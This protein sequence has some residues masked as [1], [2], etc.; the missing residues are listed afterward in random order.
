MQASARGGTSIPPFQGLT[1]P[2]QPMEGPQRIARWPHPCNERAL[3]SP[4]IAQWGRQPRQRW[5][6]PA[7]PES[8]TRCLTPT[9]PTALPRPAGGE[10]RLQNVGLPCQRAGSLLLAEDGSGH[11]RRGKRLKGEVGR[12][13]PG[14]SEQGGGVRQDH[15]SAEAPSRGRMACFIAPSDF[16][17]KT[18]I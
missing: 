3:P 12:T 17:C 11:R 7:S 1:T 14:P 2:T 5:L 18:Q 8:S 13:E 10:G 15:G 16:T 6:L 9:R 4:A